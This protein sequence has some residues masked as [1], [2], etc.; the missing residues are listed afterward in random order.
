[1]IESFG[2]IVNVVSDSCV[3]VISLISKTLLFSFNLSY[4]VGQLIVKL[5]VALVSLLVDFVLTL[6]TLLQVLTEDC[7]VFLSDIGTTLSFLYQAV[8]DC[9]EWMVQSW[10]AAFMAVGHGVQSV[11]NVVI[12]VV[13]SFLNLIESILGSI[14]CGLVLIKNSLVLVGS[15]TWDLFVFFPQKIVSLKRVLVSFIMLCMTN[16]RDAVNSLRS[17]MYHGLRGVHLFVSDIPKESLYGLSLC[18]V[19]GFLFVKYHRSIRP[20]VIRNL[21]YILNKSQMTLIAAW[22]YLEAFTL[23]LLTNQMTPSN[24]AY[25]FAAGA[26]NDVQGDDGNHQDTDQNSQDLEERYL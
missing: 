8:L 26:A 9:V 4:F 23:W 21:V 3:L 16:L 11:Q 20:L 5:G 1:M 25:H 22:T 12:F 15:T 14:Y 17:S 18:L 24:E 19:L 7:F 10:V 2:R 13:I 6:Q